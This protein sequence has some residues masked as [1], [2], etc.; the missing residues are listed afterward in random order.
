MTGVEGQASV[1]HILPETAPVVIVEMVDQEA[2]VEMAVDVGKM[3]LTCQRSLMR[4]P[5]RYANK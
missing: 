2:I 5:I 3:N 4:L 1:G